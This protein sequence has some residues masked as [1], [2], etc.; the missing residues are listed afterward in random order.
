MNSKI[1][2]DEANNKFYTVI[3]GSEAYLRY[4]MV[5]SKTMEMI[6]TY[7]PQELRSR[8]IAGEIVLKGLKFAEEKNFKIIPVCSYVAAYIKR[9]QEFEHLVA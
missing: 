3:D 4:M 5:N 7:V 8:G 9:H 6:K 1:K 2:H